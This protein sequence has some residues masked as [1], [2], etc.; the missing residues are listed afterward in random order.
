[1]P[2]ERKRRRRENGLEMLQYFSLQ[3]VSSLLNI[4]SSRLRYWDRIGLVKPSLREKGKSFYAFQDLICLKTAEGLVEKGLPAKKIKSSILS[5]QKRIPE[6]D[7]RLSNK[8][9]YIFGNRVIISHKNRLV[10]S[11]SGQL[12]FRFD[13]DHFAEEVQNKVRSFQSAKTAEDW[14]EEG[15]KYDGDEE[16]YQLA[17]NAYREAIKLDQNCAEAYVNM[18]TIHYNQGRFV[19]AERC[20]RLALARDPYN[21]KAYFNLGNTLDEMNCIDE[22]SQ[23]YEKALEADPNF[24]DA[25]YNLAA[26]CEKLGQKDRAIKHWKRYLTFDSDSKHAEI[27]RRRVR[28]LQ[29]LRV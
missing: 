28:A 19:D 12:V 17:L 2:L 22:A 14:F 7:E 1:M 27:A 15:L 25:H 18:G 29:V 13:V 4:K 26:T 10:D 24:P 11:Y 9:I 23:C 21:A 6:F 8:R 3:E 20:C 5:L 16:T